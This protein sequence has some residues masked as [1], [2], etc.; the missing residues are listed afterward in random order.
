[1]TI[2]V[3]LD[4]VKALRRRVRK[5]AMRRAHRVLGELTCCCLLTTS[6]IATIRF[7]ILGSILRNGR[8]Q[9]QLL[10]R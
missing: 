10:E 9:G 3:R 4:A 1:L 5:T 8:L 2:F 6:L 7:R